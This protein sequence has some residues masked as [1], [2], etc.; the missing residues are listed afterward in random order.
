MAFPDYC[1]YPCDIH[2]KRQLG[3]K[4][5]MPAPRPH[6]V[7]E[8]PRMHA[9]PCLLGLLF[10]LTSSL[11]S[12]T[13]VIP[14]SFYSPVLFLSLLPSYKHVLFLLF[15]HQVVSDSCSPMDCS[16]PGF[17]VHGISQQEYWSGLPFPSPGG[18]PNPETRPV[19]PTLAGRFFTTEPPEKPLSMFML[20]FP[21]KTPSLNF[22][23][24]LCKTSAKRRLW[25]LA[26]GFPRTVPSSHLLFCPHAC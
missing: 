3:D 19:P 14:S 8:G 6:P 23:S 13:P 16:L 5:H 9:R 22:P 2:E 7:W 24:L 1:G 21:L 4:C 15:S 11:L 26:L 20:C 17:S 12:L 25:F 18:L 10:F